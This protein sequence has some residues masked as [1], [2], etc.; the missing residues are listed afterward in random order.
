MS[1]KQIVP[2]VYELSSGPVNLWLVEEEQGLTLID[3]NYRAKEN[4]ILGAI[5]Q[6]GKRSEDIRNILLTHCHPDHVGSL[7]ALK[8]ASGAAAWMH[9][10]DAEV[11]RGRGQ[12]VLPPRPSPGLL[13]AI[14]FRLV[15][16]GTPSGVSPAEIEH[17]VEDGQVLPFGAGITAVHTPGHS[18]GHTAYLYPGGGGV[19]FIGDACANMAGLDYSII[20]ADIDEARRSLRKLA[21]FDVQAICFSHGRPLLG[22]AV[23]KF[24]RKWT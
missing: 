8:Q 2:H 12:N 7:A 3:T 15:I 24:K 11:A 18:E 19:L 4:E 17:E 5:R 21:A 6:L 20:Y 22:K 9:P 10:A 23:E 16:A 1:F 13:N 14:L